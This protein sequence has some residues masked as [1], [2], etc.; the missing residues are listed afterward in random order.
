MVGVFHRLGDKAI[1][2]TQQAFAFLAG[3]MQQFPAVD[4][5]AAATGFDSSL[6]LPELVIEPEAVETKPQYGDQYDVYDE[7]EEYF[8]SYID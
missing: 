7:Y 4:F 5:A 3:G 6:E 2:S 1:E 8:D